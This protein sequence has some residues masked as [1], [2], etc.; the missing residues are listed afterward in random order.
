MLPDLSWQV[1]RGEP[2]GYLN[3]RPLVPP[4]NAV[5]YVQTYVYSPG[6]QRTRLLLGAAGRVKVWLNG[7]AVYQSPQA[8]QPRPDDAQAEVSLKAGWNPLLIKVAGKGPDA[9][10]YLRVAGG[11]GLQVSLTPEAIK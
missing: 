11:A 3:L 7:A 6:D 5:A 10:L 8:L 1:L 2:N 9:G 4:A